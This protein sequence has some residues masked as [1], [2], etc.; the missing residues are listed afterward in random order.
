MPVTIVLGVSLAVLALIAVS[1]VL[2]FHT[3][4][5]ATTVSEVWSAIPGGL[6]YAA[7]P[8]A[9][10]SMP[11]D[12]IVVLL[13]TQRIPRT[14]LALVAGVSL[15][16]AGALMQGYTRNPLAE[17][18]IL[19][20]GSGAAAAVAV[21]VSLGWLS[22]E[23]TYTGPAMVGALVV[24]T[25]LFA[26][27]SRGPASGSPLAFILSGMALSALF[28]A[29]VSALVITNESALD[30]L[31]NWATGSVAGRDFGVVWAT[32]P[33][34]AVALAVAVALAPGMN[35]LALGEET[36]HS[37]G[38]S[39]RGY[40]VA[41]ILAVAAL[42]AAAV[43]AAG[44]VA[45]IGLAAPHI[46]RGV[47]GTDYRLIVPLSALF[48]GLLALWADIL[49]R[50]VV[51]PGELPMGVLLA[52]MGVPIFIFLVRRGRIEGGGL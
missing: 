28:S 22:G 37:L 31:R 15:G 17:P 51:A 39:V 12:D 46:V 48:G 5:R 50:V 52:V 25:L 42:S 26:L 23:A 18:G 35:M 7:S 49:G 13:G 3:G 30:A 24:T 21:G 40:R 6:R 36:A 8:D 47:L 9:R 34:A 2:S 4:A 27:S 33:I 10:Q 1:A 29:V 14:F 32:A 11:F 38:V 16:A 44:P 41:G 19:G 45:F 20:V 43:T